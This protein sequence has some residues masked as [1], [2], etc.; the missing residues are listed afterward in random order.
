MIPKYMYKKEITGLVD[1]LIRCG[2][3][4]YAGLEDHDKDFLTA[5]CMKALGTDCYNAIIEHDNFEQ[6]VEHFVRYLLKG[7]HSQAYAL[8]ETMRNNAVEHFTYEMDQLFAERVADRRIATFIEA[9]LQPIRHLDN[10]EVTWSA[11]A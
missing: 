2:Y 9:G 11:Q 3:E 5:E 6:T 7:S 4:S 10:G 8:A 1:S